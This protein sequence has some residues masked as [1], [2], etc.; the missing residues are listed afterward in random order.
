MNDN[1]IIGNGM[2]AHE[3]SDAIKEDHGLCIFASGVSNS[4]CEDTSEFKRENELLRSVMSTSAK[5]RVLIYVSTCSVYDLSQHNS[6]MYIRHKTSMESIVRNHPSFY[7][8]RLPQVVGHTKNLNTLTNFL[9]NS[10]VDGRK[11]FIQKFATRNIIDVQDAVK[12]ARTIIV[13]NGYSNQT[14]NIANTRSDS[15]I[16][17]LKAMEKVL[18]RE[19]IYELVEAGCAYSIDTTIISSIVGNCN[20]NFD[21]NYTSRTLEKYYSIYSNSIKI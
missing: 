17:I 2:I 1:I 5:D 19:A 7:I 11:I 16:D 14:V 3:F 6:S 9:K 13:S 15:V 21:F 4:T 10:I 20:I 8:F 18:G 12:L